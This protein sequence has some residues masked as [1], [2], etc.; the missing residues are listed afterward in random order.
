MLPLML[1]VISG[2]KMSPASLTSN[3]N[4]NKNILLITI[5]I[6]VLKKKYRHMMVHHKSGQ[7]GL[8][9]YGPWSRLSY[10]NSYVTMARH[11]FKR[12]FFL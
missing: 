1:Y 5:N 8:R 2:S 11:N 10:K 6:F 4:R 12:F 9:A 3:Y 7:V